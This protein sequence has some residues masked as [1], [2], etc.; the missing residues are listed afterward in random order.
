MRKDSVQWWIPFLGVGAVLALSPVEAQEARGLRWYARLS[1]DALLLQE[2][3]LEKLRFPGTG[4]VSVV[5]DDIEFEPGFG[6]GIGGGC[7]LTPWLAVEVET[8]YGVNNIDTLGGHDVADAMV[9]QM[10]WLVNLVFQ[11]DGWKKIKP[12]LGAG[13]GGLTT[14]LSVD[15]QTWID[16]EG[17]DAWIDGSQD[18]TVL[19]FQGFAG[20]TY[21]FTD[22][23]SV[24]LRYRFLGASGPSWDVEVGSWDAE[25]HLLLTKGDIA[26]DDL[27]SHSIS[28]QFTY[29]F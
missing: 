26:C 7:W 5:G 25:N 13:A 22:N 18:D 15:D 12:F 8:G 6:L 9:A 19:A 2:T 17:D 11:Y 3:S 10:P 1:A 23:V 4:P 14:I 29:R 16:A 24:G 21:Q 28:A 20:V 27:Q